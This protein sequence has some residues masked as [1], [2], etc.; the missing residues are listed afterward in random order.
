MLPLKEIRHAG[1]PLGKTLDS[2][3]T[4]TNNSNWRTKENLKPEKKSNS[5]STNQEP[6]SGAGEFDELVDELNEFINVPANNT[7]DSNNT[8]GGIQESWRG[9]QPRN[10]T[11]DIGLILT[12]GDQGLPDGIQDFRAWYQ[13][14]NHSTF[15]PFVRGAPMSSTFTPALNGPNNPND[16]VSALKNHP[17]F[18]ATMASLSI[19]G[20]VAL[21]SLGCQGAKKL[22]SWGM[23]MVV[24][25]DPHV[26]HPQAGGTAVDTEMQPM[27]KNPSKDTALYNLAPQDE[28]SEGVTKKTQDCSTTTAPPV[29]DHQM[30][31]PFL[32]NPSD[33]EWREV[34]FKRQAAGASYID[35]LNNQSD[36][37]E[38]IK[39]LG[40]FNSQIIDSIDP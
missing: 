17:W 15:Q 32:L 28:E 3:V 35:L 21:G 27:R 2:S 6:G 10:I 30:A 22:Y 5:K 34:A 40:D 9:A 12:E 18:T 1:S 25:S 37:I 26:S 20:F 19:I 38:P 4:S 13:E 39:V 36:T 8:G 33:N 11:E 16:L 29:P 23:K 7:I 14:N 31:Q 24:N